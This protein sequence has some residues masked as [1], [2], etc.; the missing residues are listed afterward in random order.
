[1]MQY[2]RLTLAAALL[3][4]VGGLAVATP[5]IAKDSKKDAKAGPSYSPEFIKA[6]GPA[7]AALK[8]TDVAAMQSAVAAAEAA[9]KTDDDKYAVAHMRVQVVQTQMKADP[10]ADQ[11]VLAPTLQSLVDNPKTPA[12][13]KA[14][15][16]FFLGQFA[17]KKRDYATALRD[18]G[19]AQT[20]GYNEPQL[21]LI[22][23]QTRIASGDVAGGTADFGKVVDTAEASGKP[24]PEAYYR[25]ALGQSMNA[26]NK[27][28]SLVWL[29]RWLSAYPTSKNWH[30]ALTIYGLQQ[31]SL[32]TLDRDQTIDLLRLMRST[33][34]LDQYGYEEYADKVLKAGLPDEAKTVIAEGRASGKIPAAGSNATGILADANK[35][36]ALEGSLTTLSTR[37]RASATGALA[38][39]TAD[40]YLG[41]GDY[42]AAIPLYQLALTKGG[43][44]TE[45]VNLHLGTALAL[46]GD[47]SGAKAAFGAVTSAP[48]ADIAQFW[49]LSLDHPAAA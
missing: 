15:L 44:K 28:Q 45:Q 17:D 37:A 16:Y 38:S 5:A 22:I 18:Y 25:Y 47:K 2:T 27:A 35:S 42:A 23:A 41:K 26:K 4:G 24:A 43:V 10:Q 29:K 19:Q 31:G 30:D 49:V 7:Q 1:M 8:G 13:E 14:Q 11:S 6:A 36:I 20:L 12:T 3:A 33:K 21:P 34:S 9:A 39:Q 32:A 40:A 48:N 46:S